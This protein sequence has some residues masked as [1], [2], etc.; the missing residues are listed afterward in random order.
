LLSYFLFFLVSKNF[1]CD[2]KDLISSLDDA[3]AFVHHNGLAPSWHIGL[4]L[5]MPS[6][7]TVSMTSTSDEQDWFWFVLVFLVTHKIQDQ[8]RCGFTPD[9][10]EKW[11]VPG[12][13]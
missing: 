10:G 9:Q 12:T 1:F 2:S 6:L 4:T 13:W 7:G 3:E 8:E 11:I 5:V